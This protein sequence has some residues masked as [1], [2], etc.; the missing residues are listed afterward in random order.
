MA[1]LQLLQFQFV[2]FKK[3]LQHPS[4]QYCTMYNVLYSELGIW[5]QGTI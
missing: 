1:T 3:Y 5:I 2:I 4:V